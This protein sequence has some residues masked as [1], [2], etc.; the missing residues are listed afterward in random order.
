MNNKDLLRKIPKVDGILEHQE[1][2]KLVADYPEDP[3]KDALRAVIEDTRLAIK[4]GET[5]S[6]PSTSEIIRAAKKMLVEWTNPRLKRVI[7]GTGVI[8]H[9]NLGRS[10]LA[11]E[12]IGAIINAASRYTNLEYDLEKGTRGSRYDHCTAVLKRL[13][14]AESAL[15]VNNNAGAVFLVLNTLAEGKETIVSR[16][17]LVEIGGSFRIPDVMKKSGTVLREVGTTNRTY[18]EDYESAINQE[19]G[20]L[21]KAH[22]SNYRI[23]GFTRDVRVEELVSLGRQ[24]G[25]P[26]YFDAGSGLLFPLQAMTANDEPLVPAELAKGLD[27]ISFSGDKLLGAPQ[28]GIILGRE[29]FIDMMKKNPLTRALRPDKFTIAGLESTLLLY[30]DR[31]RS[32]KVIPTLRMIHEDIG[33]LR[34]RAQWIVKQART[35]CPGLSADVVR[36]DSEVGGGTLPDVAIPSFGVGLKPAGMTAQSLEVRLRGLE[37]PV[38]G[39]IEKDVFLLDMRTIGKDELGLLVEGI[40]SALQDGK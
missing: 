4:T 32:K 36:L 15:V 5:T 22:T 3:A 29:S 28:A 14:G 2:K 11:D 12:A 35:R 10:L 13:T 33:V 21:M 25:V 19:T 16:G 40:E 34:R 38:V 6:V 30:L 9:T 26:A 17:E 23:K 7:N 31:E 37:V 24:Y 1:W 27:I 20:L 18:K 39:R 8:I